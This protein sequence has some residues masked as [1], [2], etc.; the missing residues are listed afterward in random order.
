L[1]ALRAFE[2]GRLTDAIASKL[3]FEPLTVTRN[4]KPLFGVVADF[5]FVLPM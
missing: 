2:R 1:D 5:E 4:R 3:S